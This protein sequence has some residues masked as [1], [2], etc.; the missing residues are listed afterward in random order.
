MALTIGLRGLSSLF[1]TDCIVLVGEDLWVLMLIQFCWEYS[2]FLLKFWFF[3][4]LCLLD[5]Y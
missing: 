3:A 4:R 5:L 1:L 2:F